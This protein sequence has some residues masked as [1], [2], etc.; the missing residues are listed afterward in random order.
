MIYIA[1][2]VEQSFESI[3]TM[4]HSEELFISSPSLSREA[5]FQ[6][7]KSMREYWVGLKQKQ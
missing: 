5:Q 4:E 3:A 1:F 7:R 6:R 2:L